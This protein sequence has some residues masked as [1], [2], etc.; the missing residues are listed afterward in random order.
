[1]TFPPDAALGYPSGRDFAGRFAKELSV[2]FGLHI[3]AVRNHAM[4]HR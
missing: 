1:M 2:G 4:P 3:H